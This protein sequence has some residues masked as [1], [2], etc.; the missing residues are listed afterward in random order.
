MASSSLV[1]VACLEMN[2][3]STCRAMTCLLAIDSGN[4]NTVLGIYNGEEL[5]ADWRIETNA[6][7]TATECA[8][9]CMG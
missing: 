1:K 8:T 6:R 2:G 5:V 3:G 7:R 4:T 9:C